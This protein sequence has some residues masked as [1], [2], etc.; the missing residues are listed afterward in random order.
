VEPSTTRMLNALARTTCRQAPGVRHLAML[1]VLAVPPGRSPWRLPSSV[2]EGG[3]VEGE[4]GRVFPSRGITQ[5]VTVRSAPGD[6]LAVGLRQEPDRLRQP[7]SVAQ[8]TGSADELVQQLEGGI[9]PVAVT[10]VAIV[11]ND[12]G[13]AESTEQARSRGGRSRRGRWAN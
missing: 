1:G 10:E 9:R 11:A 8:V 2:G 6:E 7:G 12:L 5:P 13:A 4:T 3:D